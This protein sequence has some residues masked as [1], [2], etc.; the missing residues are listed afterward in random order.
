MR[1]PPPPAPFLPKPFVPQERVRTVG[2]LRRVRLPVNFLDCHFPTCFPRELRVELLKFYY[3]ALMLERL[4]VC[5]WSGRLNRFQHLGLCSL[6][7]PPDFHM[8]ISVVVPLGLPSYPHPFRWTPR[9]CS[10]VPRHDHEQLRV[11]HCPAKSCR[12]SAED[13]FCAL[14]SCGRSEPGLTPQLVDSRREMLLPF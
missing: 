14:W 8:R 2:L 4:V 9:R 10:H 6:V 1:A 5:H 11:E 3:V 12:L 7:R 13:W